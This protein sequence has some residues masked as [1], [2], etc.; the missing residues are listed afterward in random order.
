MR[1]VL[2]ANGITDRKIYVADSFGGLPPPNPDR[3]QQDAGHDF[4][5]HKE[6]AVSAEEVR[7][8]FARYGL[9]DEQVV[10][11]E[12]LFQETLPTLAAGPFALLRLDGDLYE[13]TY[14]ALEHLYPKLS[15][16]GYV[17]IDDFGGIVACRQAVEDYRVKAGIDAAMTE[18][19]W[20]GVWWQKPLDAAPA[21]ADAATLMDKI[22]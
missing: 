9:L 16:G 22:G 10:F 21:L 20:S 17:I 3:F 6:L 8:N 7:S 11:V 15:P 4:S 5:A 18:I 13:S 2:K 12:G 14:V 1:G 19:D